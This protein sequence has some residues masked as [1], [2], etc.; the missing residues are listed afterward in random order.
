M[1]SCF[2]DIW[3]PHSSISL[4]ISCKESL[5]LIDYKLHQ[6]ANCIR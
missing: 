5:V 2:L 3:Y 4:Y 1:L 6:I